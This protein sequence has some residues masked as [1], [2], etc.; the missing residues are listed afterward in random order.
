MEWLPSWATSI[1]KT[2][3][4]NLPPPLG[5]NTLRQ[6]VWPTYSGGEIRVQLSNEKGTSPVD[7]AKVHVARAGSAAGQI[8]AATDAEFTFQGSAG[9][10]IP[11]GQTVWSDPLDF[12]LQALELT[13]LSIQFGSTVPTEITGHPGSRTTSYVVNGDAVSSATLSG[14]ETRDRW[15]FINAIEVMA[16]SDA[17]AV[18]L[19]GDSITD[20][21]GI[22]NAFERW[23]DFLT[24]AIQEDPQIAGKVSVLNAGM[25]ANNLLTSSADMDSGL[26][27]FERDVLGRPKVKWVVVL[28]GVNDIGGQS[29][30]GLVGQITAAYQ[31]IID[32]SHDAGIL[33]YG[34]TITPFAG[35]DYAAGEALAI[36]DGINEWI[37]TSG[38]FDEVIDFAAVV[39]D[40]ANAQQLAAQYSNDGLHPSA[41]GYQAM[42]ESVDL[43][44]FSNVMP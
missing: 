12:E 37:R 42:A 34:A 25:S 39:A 24:L 41:A 20:G 14:A 8:D 27:R 19:L 9:V 28:I 44:L 5:G 23:P 21:Y 6:F 16:R 43:S 17:F 3:E 26:I 7:I 4:R 29:D 33:A 31:D 18:S 36:R 2:E 35:H 13:A 40:P 30:M 10:T 32:R 38:A 22:L 15:Y 1:Q 11:A